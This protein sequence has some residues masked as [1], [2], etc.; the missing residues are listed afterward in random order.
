MNNIAI[1]RDYMHSIK[2][3]WNYITPM[4]FY[5]NYYLT[6][7]DYLLISCKS[8]VASSFL[9]KL[10]ISAISLESVS[11]CASRIKAFV[12]MAKSHKKSI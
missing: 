11:A 3:D 1:L 10:I 2:D 5:N 12:N 4:E 8:I 7:K 6:N 9:G